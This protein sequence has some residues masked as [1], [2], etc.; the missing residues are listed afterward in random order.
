MHNKL[1][2]ERFIIITEG[3]IGCVLQKHWGKRDKKEEEVS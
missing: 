3:E 1:A 2:N